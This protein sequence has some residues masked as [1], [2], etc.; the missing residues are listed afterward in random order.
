[1]RSKSTR[2]RDA[3]FLQMIEIP[4]LQEQR[5]VRSIQMFKRPVK[6]ARKG[7]R[8]G[9]LVTQF[10]SDLLERGIAAGM[11]H[12]PWIHFLYTNTHSHHFMGRTW[13]CQ[14]Y[15]DSYRQGRESSLLQGSNCGKD[16]VPQYVN[17]SID[18]V[19][20]SSSPTS[21]RIQY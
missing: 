4:H 5:K 15:F 9:V 14:D 8:I 21:N 12:P 10:S 6:K 11:E 7:D 13:I 18:G 17:T 20:L 1:M 19:F 3:T 16:E 2:V